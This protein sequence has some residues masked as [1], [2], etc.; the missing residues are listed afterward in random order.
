V[1]S[2]P[3]AGAVAAEER[4]AF[5]SLDDLVQRV[6]SP[7]L[8]DYMLE[9]VRALP[10]SSELHAPTADA[11]AEEL[12]ADLTALH[13]RKSV[14]LSDAL[15]VHGLLEYGV[16]STIHA[17]VYHV[18][19]AYIEGKTLFAP[20]LELWANPA[21]GDSDDECPFR[22]M[23]CYFASMPSLGDFL[24]HEKRGLVHKN[25]S[26]AQG[27]ALPAA[28]QV[29][30]FQ[31]RARQMLDS[32][33]L[34]PGSGERGL[35]A[36][37]DVLA[38]LADNTTDDSL[39]ALVG[40]HGLGCPSVIQISSD[41]FWHYDERPMISRLPNKLLRHGR[42]WLV[43]QVLKWLTQ[44]N[45]A[46]K[47]RLD[48]KR[49]EIGLQPPFLSLHVR[50]GD[51]CTHRGDC[52]GLAEA[53]EQV[54]ELSSRYNLN[55]V[56]LSTPDESVIAEIPNFPKYKFATTGVTNTTAILKAF[57]MK[58][59]EEGLDEHVF[60]A[61]E[62]FRAF[63]VDIYLLSEGAGF[64]G[65]FT[66]NAARLAY[67]LMTSGPSG[68]LKPYQSLDINWCYGFL[69]GGKALIRYGNVSVDEAVNSTTL[70]LP[71]TLR[72]VLLSQIEMGC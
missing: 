66:S 47:R 26:A 61:I 63:M 62:E 57:G 38:N 68:C 55:S 1:P 56:F 72:S 31:R 10:A 71:S 17:L 12:F 58:R 27:D 25:H 48:T 6:T 3:S 43:S 41:Y 70:A 36:T 29:V 21:R 32:A 28:P 23:S 50:K 30:P 35:Q 51:A 34:Q 54:E 44:P 24:L 59:I 22:D 69:R 67:S 9:N 14:K 52:R 49:A 18:L 39:C 15:F 53:M 8:P 20:R 46:V 4:V 2:A 19:L 13:S 64:V 37:W 16:S 5:V 11:D 7:G 42:F 65:G 40:H 33:T 60:S 45:A